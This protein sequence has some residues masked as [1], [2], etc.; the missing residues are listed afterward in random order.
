MI[1]NIGYTFLLGGY[2][3][4]MVCIRDILIQYIN[5]P[6]SLFSI[7][8]IDHH[9]QWGA[10]LSHYTKELPGIA[11]KYIVGVELGE[12]I[13]LPPGYIAIDHHG[14]KSALPSS[15]EQVACLLHVTLT[16]EQQL[17]AI[18]DRAYIPGMLAFGATQEEINRIRE[19]DRRAQG[20]TEEDE[21]LAASSVR[22]HRSEQ[23]GVTI[24]KA[25]TAKYSAI[26]DLLYPF[27]QLII[28][29]DHGLVYYGTNAGLLPS[30]FSYI[31]SGEQFYSGGGI[32][33]FAGITEQGLS[34]CHDKE[35]LISIIIKTVNH[36]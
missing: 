28:V 36:A 26:T 33:G 13:P 16:R 21:Q 7:E 1:N 14:E 24:V 23:N 31:V 17:A 29:S 25:L 15:L 22:D 32:H 19:A 5:A 27:Q 6:A 3:L 18:N 4:E 20:V 11:S 9:L 35:Y 30:L 8:F 34:T 10:Q 12:D 2:D